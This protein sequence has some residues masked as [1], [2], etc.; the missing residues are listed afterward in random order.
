MLFSRPLAYESGCSHVEV[1]YAH[2]K[3]ELLGGRRGRKISL[4][5]L[6]VDIGAAE[7][8]DRAPAVL[9]VSSREPGE[10]TVAQSDANR[11]STGCARSTV[12]CV[13]K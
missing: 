11:G 13:S 9:S 6:F 2:H 10:F 5:C 4:I 3:Y 7:V 8:R 12:T 1:N